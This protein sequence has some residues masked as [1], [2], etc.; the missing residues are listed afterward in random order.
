MCRVLLFPRLW[1]LVLP[2]ELRDLPPVNTSQC[3]IVL[4]SG[5]IFES[6]I[7]DL[8]VHSVCSAEMMQDVF[9]QN[10][11]AGWMVRD[12]RLPV[13]SPLESNWM[14]DMNLKLHRAGTGPPRGV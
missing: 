5:Q 4:L 8:N 12:C 3:P 14:L 13:P 7:E 10:V 11:I 9:T 1:L 6:P 2:L